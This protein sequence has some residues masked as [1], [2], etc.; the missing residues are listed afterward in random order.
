MPEITDK[1]YVAFDVVA[2]YKISKIYSFSI[3][4]EKGYETT[5]QS[6]TSQT[7]GQQQTGGTTNTNRVPV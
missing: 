3:N 2:K 4:V 6:Q 5:T 1:G 7:T